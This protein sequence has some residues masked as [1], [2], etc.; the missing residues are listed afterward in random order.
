MIYIDFANV[1]KWQERL[2]WH[3]DL[4]RLMQLLS[5]FDQI[6]D[7]KIYTGTLLD[8]PKS[9]HSIDEVKRCGYTVV[10]KPVKKIKIPIDVSSIPADSPAIIRQFIR[11]PLLQKFNIQTIEYLNARIREL[12]QSGIY[13]LEDLKCNFDVEIGIDMHGDMVNGKIENFVLISGDSDFADPLMLLLREQKKVILMM[14]HRKVGREL[15][16]LKAGCLIM[17]DIDKIK[18]FI[19]WPKDDA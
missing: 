4:K 6:K 13:Y 9:V 15:N 19:C 7:V 2:G 5:S 16:D 1:I 18:K 17:Y 3:I 8:E 12:N 10:T 14:T 11:A